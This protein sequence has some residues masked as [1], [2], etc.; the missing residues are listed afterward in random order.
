MSEQFQRYYAKQVF[1]VATVAVLCVIASAAP[2]SAESAAELLGLSGTKGGLIVH[3]GCGD[4][5]LTAQLR[6]G[7]QYLVH[8]LDTAADDVIAARE[9][10]TERGATVPVR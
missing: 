6:L 7:D 9:H 10:I 5:K 1:A 4:G 3:L 8:G 2:A